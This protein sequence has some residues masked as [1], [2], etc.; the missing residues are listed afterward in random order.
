MSPVRFVISGAGFDSIPGSMLARRTG[1]LAVLATLMVA[2]TIGLGALFVAAPAEAQLV[3]GRRALERADFQRAIRAFDRAER[4]ERLDRD[5]LISLYE[6]RVIARFAVGTRARARRDLQILGALDPAHTFPV[7]VPP[8]VGEAL[9]TTVRESGGG[10]GATLTWRD[11]GEGSTLTIE[12]ARDPAE[13][14]RAVRVHT[15][16]GDGAW[17]TS[18]AREVRVA[19]G[20]GVIVAAWVELLGE[21][22]VVLAH[23]ATEAAPNLHG[24]ALP[25][26]RPLE[27]EPPIVIEEPPTETTSND[28]ALALGLG[29]GLGGAALVAVGVVLGIVFGTQT[30]PDTQP[31]LPMTVGF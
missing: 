9:A 24:E 21:R 30:S 29:L 28:D 15:R 13:I 5:G 3:A 1:S 26:P 31:S 14:V 20:E 25:P 18:A 17:S 4:T 11:E 12:V 7:E 2:T 6:G 27:E 19:H 8:E 23:E 16:V 22:D 10:L